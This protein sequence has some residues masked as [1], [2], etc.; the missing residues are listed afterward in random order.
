MI[1]LRE[2]EGSKF[3]LNFWSGLRTWNRR[4]G[5]GGDLGEVSREKS[6]MG[7]GRRSCFGEGLVALAVLQ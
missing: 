7:G 6:G 2:G 4:R 3:C 1:W 5:E